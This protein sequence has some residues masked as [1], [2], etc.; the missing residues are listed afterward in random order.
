MLSMSTNSGPA[1][2]RIRE[3]DGNDD[4]IADTLAKLQ[5]T[6]LDAAPFPS[7]IKA[8]GGLPF[9]E[10]SR[11]PSPDFVHPCFQCG[12]FLSRWRVADTGYRLFS[13]RNPWAWPNA[14]YWRK[15]VK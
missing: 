4:D 1:V 11:S 13:L 12:L 10:A 7:L 9:T 2:Y 15:V 3:V 8:T 5:S 6:F 14:L